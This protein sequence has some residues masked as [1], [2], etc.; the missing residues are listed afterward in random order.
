SGVPVTHRMITSAAPASAFR[1]GVVVA[2]AATR[3]STGWFPGCSKRIIEWP[4]LTILL[5]MPWPISP[6]P[7]MPIFSMFASLGSGDVDAMILRVSR[8]VCSP[9]QYAGKLEGRQQGRTNMKSF[10]GAPMS[11]W[12]T[13][14]VVDR[15]Q[16]MTINRPQARNAVNLETAQAIADALDILD[17]SDQVDL[18]ILTGAAQTFCSGMDLK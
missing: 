4:R 1:L 7:I 2:P 16:V 3:S 8:S 9:A 17:T 12:L 10:G 6:M 14:E 5:A 15:I 18:G 11:E 13:V